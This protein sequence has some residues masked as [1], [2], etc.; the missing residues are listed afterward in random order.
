MSTLSEAKMKKLA[1]KHLALE[2]E[3]EK[4]KGE[5]AEVEGEKKVKITRDSLKGSK[6]PIKGK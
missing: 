6:N 3:M 4:V 1:D 5:L 2:Q